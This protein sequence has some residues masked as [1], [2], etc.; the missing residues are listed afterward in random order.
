MYP[1]SDGRCV[2]RR[3]GI[4]RLRRGRRVGKELHK[5][6]VWTS[7]IDQTAAR[8]PSQLRSVVC[9]TLFRAKAWTTEM[10]HVLVS[11]G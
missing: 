7:I 5:I 1:Y 10:I 9:S 4:R 8:V 3:D 6:A 11:K 2:D